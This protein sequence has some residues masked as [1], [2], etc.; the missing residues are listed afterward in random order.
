MKKIIVL[1]SLMLFSLHCF[2][3]EFIISPAIGYSNI[4][5]STN[6]S[7]TVGATKAKGDLDFSLNAMD[8]SI[9][10]GFI[11]EENG[12]TFIVNNDFAVAGQGTAKLSR[13]SGSLSFD[14]EKPF[15]WEMSV[16]L[17]RTFKACKNKLYIN[18]GAGPAVGTKQFSIYQK[19]A[20]KKEKI[21]D[22]FS[23]NFGARVQLG[24]QYFFAEKMGINFIIA[25]TIAG[26][27]LGQTKI[28]GMTIKYDTPSFENIFTIKA[29]FMFRI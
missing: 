18:I 22:M 12:F 19:I 15:A 9:A 8:L 24:T 10:L 14:V 27:N 11:T 25:D 7:A 5:N 20:G 1:F 3:A 2:A 17:G 13:N 23:T 16:I 21:A 29:G 26:A 28:S 4:D 6:W